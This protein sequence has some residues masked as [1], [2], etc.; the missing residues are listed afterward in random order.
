MTDDLRALL[1]VLDGPVRPDGEFADALFAEIG[2]AVGPE[3]LSIA[4]DGPEHSAPVLRRRFATLDPDPRADGEDAR[5]QS[6]AGPWDGAIAEPAPSTSNRSRRR[7]LA[8]VAAA[9]VVVVVVGAV[10]IRHDTPSRIKIAPAAGGVGACAGKAYV[11]NR[12]GTVS[13]IKTAAG[14]AAAPIS[15]GNL[16]GSVVITRDG[17]HVYVANKGDGTLSVIATATGVVSDPIQVGSDPSAL[18]MTPDGRYAYVANSS[19]A[20]VHMITTK[21]RLVSGPIPVGSTPSALA[22]TPDGRFLYVANSGDGTVCGSAPDGPERAGR[23]RRQWHCVGSRF[24][25]QHS[26]RV[27]DHA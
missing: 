16:P 8:Y 13:V 2:V 17:K 20:T 12:G 9:V 7:L 10:L 23:L 19:D 5:R 15:V 21:N 18:A 11:I 22:M 24:R 14:V 1:S 6:G 25:R 26:E 27:G 4:V 3:E